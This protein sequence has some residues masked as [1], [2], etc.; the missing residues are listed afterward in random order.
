M[1]INYHQ[2]KAVSAT[3]KRMLDITG[4]AIGLMLLSPILLCAAIAIWTNMGKPV[5]FRQDRPGHQGKPFKIIK[6]RTM[7]APQVG[8]IWFRSDEMRLTKLGRFLRKTSINP[9]GQGLVW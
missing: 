7:R 8:E 6:F 2:N 5:L 3:S 9:R 4:A 1:G